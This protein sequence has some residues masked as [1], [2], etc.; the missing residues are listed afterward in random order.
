MIITWLLADV[1]QGPPLFLSLDKTKSLG[2]GAVNWQSDRKLALRFGRQIDADT[3]GDLY[4]PFLG[5]RAMS[6]TD[7]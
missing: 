5:A 3:F 4:F 2:S 6:C 7:E 1:S